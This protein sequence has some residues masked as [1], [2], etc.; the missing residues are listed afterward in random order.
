MQPWIRSLAMGDRTEVRNLVNAVR[1]GH[2]TLI[3]PHWNQLRR[4]VEADHAARVRALATHGVGSLLAGLSG[5]IAWDGEVLTFRYPVDRT[6]FLSGRGITLIPS[7]FCT[8]APVT[9]IDP[10]LPPTLVYP[11][12]AMVAAA[13]QEIPEGLI[14]LLG[15]TRAECLHLL[16]NPHTTS[17]IAARLGVSVGSASKQTTILRN[18]GLID[19]TRAGSAVIHQ[20]TPLGTGLLN[21]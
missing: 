7:Y 16:L 18:A 11:A 5:V 12:Q 1:H 8:G 4:T 6:L 20:I 3:A 2:E 15:Q 10:T 17:Q 19:S 14:P 13:T 21:I 9:L